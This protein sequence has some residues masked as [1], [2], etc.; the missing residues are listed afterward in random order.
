M[1]RKRN[2]R[3]EESLRTLAALER[4]YTGQQQQTNRLKMLRILKEAP[5]LPLSEVSAMIGCSERSVHRWLKEY[6]QHGLDALIHDENAD[7]GRMRINRSELEELRCKLKSEHVGT[8]NEIQRWLRDRF[9]VEYSL[10]AISNLLQH[11][12]KARRVWMIP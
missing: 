4:Q 2:G 9:G 3:I 7:P 5:S 12:L 1:P 11:R 8:L 10:K 6:T